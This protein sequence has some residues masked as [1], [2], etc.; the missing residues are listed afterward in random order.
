M[1]A[2][3]VFCRVGVSTG[4]PHVMVSN[5]RTRVTAHHFCHILLARSKSQ[6]LEQ[7]CS[8]PT[9]GLRQW[10]PPLAGVP[11][12]RC[13]LP[14]AHMAA[15][16]TSVFRLLFAHPTESYKLRSHKGGRG[17]ACR[18]R[19]PQGLGA[20]KAQRGRGEG[21]FSRWLPYFI[22]F[23][24]LTCYSSVLGSVELVSK[25]DVR[26]ISKGAEASWDQQ[27]PKQQGAEP[28]AGTCA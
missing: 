19:R 14:P 17:L 20:F 18:S 24:I 23:C 15:L 26:N 5:S 12:P 21:G 22:H 16:G 9:A 7:H 4:P 27:G 2:G 13:S 11:H 6:S 3:L 28:G 8:V 25:N 10:L 1:S